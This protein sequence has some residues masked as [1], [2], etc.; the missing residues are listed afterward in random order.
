MSRHCW[1]GAH[2]D[3]RGV[4]GH[5]RYCTGLINL[6][7]FAQEPRND[8][9]TQYNHFWCQCNDLLEQVHQGCYRVRGRL[10][11]ETFS[12]WTNRIFKANYLIDI[13]NIIHILF[14]VQPV[15]MIHN[16]FSAEMYNMFSAEIYNIFSAGAPKWTFATLRGSCLPAPIYRWPTFLSSI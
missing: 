10:G 3:P 5:R 4:V 6:W 11:I 15:Y 14:N 13:W 7:F 8:F 2:W 16:M 12:R 9:W 1:L